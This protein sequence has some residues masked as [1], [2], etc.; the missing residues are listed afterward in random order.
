MD[1]GLLENLLTARF[2][3][4]NEEFFTWGMAALKKNLPVPYHWPLATCIPT[5]STHAVVEN[6]TFKSVFWMACC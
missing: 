4:K 6:Q 2:T 3:K 1:R 5:I